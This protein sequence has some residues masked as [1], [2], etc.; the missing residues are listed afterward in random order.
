VLENLN[1]DFIILLRTR[2]SATGLAALKRRYRHIPPE[3]IE[4]YREVGGFHAIGRHPREFRIDAPE[5]VLDVDDEHG[6]SKRIEGAIPIGG[7]C[8][9]HAIIMLGGKIGSVGFGALFKESVEWVAPGLKEFLSVPDPLWPWIEDEV[10]E[11]G[12]GQPTD[13]GVVLERAEAF[14]A[15]ATVYIY[16]D[17]PF[18][19]ASPCL[20]LRSAEEV[21][22][23][24]RPGMRPSMTIKA[25]RKLVLDSKPQ[26]AL[27]QLIAAFNNAYAARA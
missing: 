5:G 24:H 12:T 23:E 27:P 10:S 16:G 21:P 26:M 8:G 7:D 25:L 1:E 2:P 9:G 20:V 17:P 4:L 15:A 19:A 3:L 14:P 18:R 11:V 13:L 22:A 6:V